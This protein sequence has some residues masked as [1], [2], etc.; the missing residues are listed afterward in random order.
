MDSVQFDEPKRAQAIALLED[1]PWGDVEQE[2]YCLEVTLALALEATGAAIE[3]WEQEGF[4]R[5]RDEFALSAEEVASLDDEW[6]LA[7]IARLLYTAARAYGVEP[8]ALPGLTSEGS[9][10]SPLTW[11]EDGSIARLLRGLNDLLYG[12]PP[13]T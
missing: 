3:L 10:T 4:H 2:I 7:Y 11:G 13:M 1:L 6:R 5:F 9:V 12:L 8:G